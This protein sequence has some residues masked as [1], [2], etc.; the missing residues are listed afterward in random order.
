[1]QWHVLSCDDRKTYSAPPSRERRSEFDTT[2]NKKKKFPFL[3][4]GKQITALKRKKTSSKNKRT[5]G[6]EKV[7]SAGPVFSFF[8]MKK[9]FTRALK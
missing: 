4:H 7:V 6:R 5:Q 8:T 2:I 9:R 1:V 3:V